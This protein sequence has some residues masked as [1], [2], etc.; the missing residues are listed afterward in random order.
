MN[1]PLTLAVS[2][3]TTGR[4]AYARD[5]NRQP[6]RAINFGLLEGIT[7]AVIALLVFGPERLPEMAR[8]AAKLIARFRSEASR[9]IDELKRAA[10]IDGLDEELK[11]IRSELRGAGDEVRKGLQHPLDELKQVAEGGPRSAVG[12]S[13]PGGSDPGADAPAPVDPEAT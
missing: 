12:G 6:G 7:V 4:T 10:E 9:S 2:P 3:H 11:A 5:G 8:N 1:V 13:D